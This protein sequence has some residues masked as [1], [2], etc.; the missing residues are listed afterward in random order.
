MSE[1]DVLVTVVTL[2]FNQEKY[3]RQCLESIVSQKTTFRFELIVHDDA[4][5]DNTANITV[6]T[7]K[8][9]LLL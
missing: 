5:S 9:T 3:I 6:N 2:A 8:N 4:S 1:N 7:S